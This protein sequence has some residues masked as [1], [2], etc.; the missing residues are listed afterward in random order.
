MQEQTKE[1]D[2][3]NIKTTNWGRAVENTRFR[4]KLIVGVLVFGGILLVLPSFLCND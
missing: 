3:P 2:Y 4:N 1:T